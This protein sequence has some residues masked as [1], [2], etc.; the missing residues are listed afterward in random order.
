MGIMIGQETAN[1]DGSRETTFL[2][3]DLDKTS[4][5]SDLL[6]KAYYTIRF[7]NDSEAILNHIYIDR[8]ANIWV[9]M[10]N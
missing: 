9:I 3:F 6:V 7:E 2:V 4:K 5:S 8:F 1:V 10:S